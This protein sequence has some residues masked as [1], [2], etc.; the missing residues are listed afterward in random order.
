MEAVLRHVK[1]LIN[2]L[3]IRVSREQLDQIFGAITLVQ[4]RNIQTRVVRGPEAAAEAAVPLGRWASPAGRDTVVP[5]ALHA[6]PSTEVTCVC[7]PV[8]R[9]LVRHL[10]I[11]MC[12]DV[13][14]RM[15]TYRVRAPARL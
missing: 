2:K 10:Q 14:V 9:L 1:E 5:E 6:P 7:I 4:K 11:I 15:R 8:V 3:P 13:V 12:L